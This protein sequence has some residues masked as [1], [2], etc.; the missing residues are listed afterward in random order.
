MTH[1]K[2]RV[3]I[4][5]AARDAKSVFG[6]IAEL[7]AMGYPYLIVCGERVSHPHVVYRE[8]RGKYDALN[9]G[10]EQLVQEAEV[11][12][13]NDVDAVIYGLEDGLM[14]FR[15]PSLGMQF[16]KIHVDSGPQRR[17]YRLMDPIRRLLPIAASGELV[18][19]RSTAIAQ[20]LPMPPCKSEDTYLLFRLRE[21]GLKVAFYEGAW[22]TTRRTISNDEETA[23]KRRTVAG[24]YQALSLTR[25]GVL[26]SLFYGLLP[27]VAPLLYFA[28]PSGAAWCQGIWHGIQDYLRG[29]RSGWF[30]PI[31]P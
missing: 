3:A 20:V 1:P 19:L 10:L 12:V 24:I 13:L 8:A 31:G 28:G 7:E 9:F 18:F 23:Y 16:S 21:L 5:V 17:F 15:D 11:I 26:V 29:D 27:F 6:K 30:A 22:I 25:P 4:L 14:N 2:A